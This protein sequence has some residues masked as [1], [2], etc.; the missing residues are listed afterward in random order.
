MP[1]TSGKRA[2]KKP[3]VPYDT[4]TIEVELTT[5]VGDTFES[6]ASV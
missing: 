4:V 6:P 1:S 3:H 2:A 5:S